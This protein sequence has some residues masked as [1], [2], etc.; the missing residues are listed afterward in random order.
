MKYIYSIIAFILLFGAGLNG[1]HYSFRYNPYYGMNQDQL[2]LALK[3]AE[4]L[5]KNGKIWTAVGTG[6]MVAGGILTFDGIDNL[7][8]DNGSDFSTFGAGIGLLCVSA[9]PL[10]YGL[11]AWFTGSERSNLIEI[12]LLANDDEMLSFKSTENGVG[13][14][15]EF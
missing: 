7:T 11:I 12:E 9:L 13:L 1:Q 2:E 15:F 3:Q 14:V 10:G 8:L 4:K 6:M 5:E